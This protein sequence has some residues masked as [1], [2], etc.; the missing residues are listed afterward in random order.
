MRYVVKFCVVPDESER[1]QIWMPVLGS[2]V[3]ELS[4]LIAGSSH[5]VIEPS[6]MPAIVSASKLQ[7]LDADV[8]RHGDG[9]HDRRDVVEGPGGL[10]AGRRVRRGRR[11]RTAPLGWRR[12]YGRHP[13][14]PRSVVHGDVRLG[15]LELD[16]GGL[17]ERRGQGRPGAVERRRRQLGRRRCGRARP[18]ATPAT[19]PSAMSG[20]TTRMRRVRRVMSVRPPRKRRMTARRLKILFGGEPTRR[21]PAGEA[22]GERAVTRVAAPC[23]VVRER[24]K[25]RP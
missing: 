4:A 20:T 9:R 16:D 25:M 24:A 18:P 21:W 17:Q 3:P 10:L 2:V 6:K 5:V 15:L 13:S 8:V 7:L 11:H 23:Q 22:R 19:S 1:R 12:R 14:R